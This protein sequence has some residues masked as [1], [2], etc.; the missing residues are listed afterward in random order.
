MHLR[1]LKHHPA[2]SA[3]GAEVR[4]ARP[5]RK[6]PRHHLVRRDSDRLALG[7]A[8]TRPGAH[9]Y[10]VVRGA[11]HTS[12]AA[13]PASFTSPKSAAAPRRQTSAAKK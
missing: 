6:I 9:L 2:L 1:Y 12:N 3:A 5:L 10:V 4:R 7:V 11:G 13:A 8:W